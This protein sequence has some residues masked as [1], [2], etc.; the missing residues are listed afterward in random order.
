[1][2]NAQKSFTEQIRA[3]DACEV[4]RYSAL[5]WTTRHQRQ[6]DSRRL[7]ACVDRGNGVFRRLA[8]AE[9]PTTWESDEDARSSRV[10]ESRRRRGPG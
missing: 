8:H 1:M 7:V 4:V 5:L 2:K 9:R 10:E 6:T 3:R